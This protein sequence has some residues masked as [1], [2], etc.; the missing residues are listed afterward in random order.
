MTL[1]KWVPRN[2]LINDF[3]SM[4][5][6]IFNDGWNKSIIS[7]NNPSVDII[8][9]ENEFELTAD[10]PGLD[11]KNVNLSIQEGVLK[12]TADQNT[13]NDSKDAY[14][15]RERYS[16]TYDRS[17][18]LPNNVVEEKINASFKNGSLKVILPKEEV[19]KPI[20]KKIKIS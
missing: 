6:G 19:V 10:L 3:D 12:L 4:L 7:S 17:F 11:K 16:K 13:N 9:N 14:W 20:V 1:V 2:T 8:E 18:T 5:D 15:L